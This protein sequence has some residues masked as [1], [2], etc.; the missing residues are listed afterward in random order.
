MKERLSLALIKGGD[1]GLPCIV[2]GRYNITH[3]FQY[4]TSSG[5]AAQGIH[6][7]CVGRAEAIRGRGKWRKHDRGA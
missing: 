1:A 2:C 6:L 3:T 5:H 4:G 7:R